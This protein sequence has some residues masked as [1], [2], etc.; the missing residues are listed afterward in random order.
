MEFIPLKNGKLLEIR[1][2]EP[3]DSAA[4]LAFTKIIGSETPYLNTDEN[5]WPQSVTEETQ[6]LA[7]SLITPRQGLF[8]HI[9]E[10]E[11]AGLFSVYPQ[12]HRPRT[13]QNAV[14][15]VAIRESCW[16][17]GLGAISTTLAID[18]A[19]EWGYH[20]LCL[21]ANAENVRALSLYRRFGFIECGRRR[22]HLFANGA[23][24]DEILME[25][26]L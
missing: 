24:Y 4:L 3:E 5:G 14:F 9:V 2:A 19:R 22:E 13:K 1:E 15:G 16:H 17:L 8:L 18:M 25:L 23:Y 20:K 10:H 11:I 21:D 6:R 26:M 7:A 12:D